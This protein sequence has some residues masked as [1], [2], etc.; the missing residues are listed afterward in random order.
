M[1]EKEVGM[2]LKSGLSQFCLISAW[3]GHDWLVISAGLKTGI[4]VP[5]CTVASKT[6]CCTAPTFNVFLENTVST[7]SMLMRVGWIVSRSAPTKE[8][9]KQTQSSMLCVCPECR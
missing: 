2:P 7:K 3:S 6:L 1:S 5:F 8:L 9:H 4:E